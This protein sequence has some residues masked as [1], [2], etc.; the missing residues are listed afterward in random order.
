MSVQALTWVLEHSVAEHSARL[1]AIA[2]A[3][4]AGTDGANAYPSIGTIAREARLGESTVRQ[5]IDRLIDLG[6]LREVGVSSHRTRIFAFPHVARRDTAES[7]PPQNLRPR[8]TRGSTPQDL[9]PDT[10]GPAPEPSEPEE[11]PSPP[12]P[13]GE[14]ALRSIPDPGELLPVRPAGK[15]ARDLTAWHEAL[16]GF[17]RRHFTTAELAQLGDAR[18]LV[19]AA[20][21]VRDGSPLTPARLRLALQRMHYLTNPDDGAQESAA[22]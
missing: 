22:A 2:L 6:E 19:E 15:R 7:A 8:R 3:N 17:A 10:A 5:A 12:A 11:E 20:A 4:H 14:R 13:K 1:V 9:A 21:R 18:V 16:D